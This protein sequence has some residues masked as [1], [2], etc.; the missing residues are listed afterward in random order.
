MV[1]ATTGS[2]YVISFITVRDVE[3][4]MNARQQ[5]DWLAPEMAYATEQME[6]VPAI[7]DTREKLVRE[8]VNALVIAMVEENVFW[9]NASVI[10]NGLGP[11]VLTDL[12]VQE[13]AL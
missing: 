10:P 1:N 13:T 4:R 7:L 8:V 3:S 11:R 2:A 6:T 9:V 5:R 12:P